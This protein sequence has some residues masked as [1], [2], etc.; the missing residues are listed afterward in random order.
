MSKRGLNKTNHEKPFENS[1][2]VTYKKPT[3]DALSDPHASFY[4]LNKNMKKHLKHLRKVKY[5]LK[6]SQ[7]KSKEEKLRKNKLIKK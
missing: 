4:F 2:S 7:L 3:Y 6:Y 1:W 5:K